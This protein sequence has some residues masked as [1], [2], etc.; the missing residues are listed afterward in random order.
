[1]QMQQ[2]PSRC[3]QAP[4]EAYMQIIGI[5]LA[6][7]L[8]CIVVFMFEVDEE[9]RE[10]ARQRFQTGRAAPP[11]PPP[12]ISRPSALSRLIRRR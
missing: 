4:R 9:E 7:I 1:M 10:E 11:Q 6:V 8:L 2:S 5:F 3:R 12:R